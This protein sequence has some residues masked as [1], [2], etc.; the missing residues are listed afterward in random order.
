MRAP[1][2]MNDP[3]EYKLHETNGVIINGNPSNQECADA[4]RM[5]S[6]A[7]KERACAV[8]IASFSVDKK[9][10]WCT[11]VERGCNRMSLWT[12][13]AESHAGV[14]LIFDRK[15][16][17]S[18]FSLAFS[19]DAF[20]CLCK[21]IQYVDADVISQSEEMFW[22]AHETYLDEAH[23]QDLF[24]KLED[25]APEQEY[26]FL[27]INRELTDSADVRLPIKDSLCGIITGDRFKTQ[28]TILQTQLHDAI[29][30]SNGDIS[31]FEMTYDLQEDPLYSRA[32]TNE[33]IE[34][35]CKSP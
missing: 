34:K 6:N 2:K 35:C 20:Q 28:D 22:E 16:L 17:E 25:Y 29:I 14:C 27:L 13:Y 12:Y 7:I 24:I 23:I 31:T 11:S 9:P 33:L 30:E 15:K 4:V 18:A 5:H 10:H 1:G 8:R 3:H 19:G 32:E 26:R 21:P